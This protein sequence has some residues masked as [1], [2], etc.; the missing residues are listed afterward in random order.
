MPHTLVLTLLGRDRAGLVELVAQTLTDHGAN[1][2]DSRMSRLGGRFAGIL[3]VE[4]AQEQSISLT[5][6]LRA[7]ESHGLS[8]AVEDAGAAVQEGRRMKLSLLG[9]DRPGIVRQISEALA[10]RRVNVEELATGTR[11]APMS[12]DLLFHAE[13]SLLVPPEVSAIELGRALESLAADLMVDLS[14]VE[15]Q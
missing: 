7:L 11:S 15:D 8:V 4:V 5:T 1:W 6:A 13:A 2:L 10:A 12:G 14:L 3:M 9:Q